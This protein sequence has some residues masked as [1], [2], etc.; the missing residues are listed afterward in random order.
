[1]A[2]HG[3]SP[4]SDR[5]RPLID[6]G[7]ALAFFLLLPPDLRGYQAVADEFAVSVRTVERHGREGNWWQ[8]ARD[9]DE[10]AQ[11]EAEGKLVQARVEQMGEYDQLIEGAIVHVAREIAAGRARPNVSD[12]IRLIKAR[13]ELWQQLDHP[14]PTPTE[15]AATAPASRTAAHKLEVVRAL[16]ESGALTGLLAA[17]DDTNGYE[18][19]DHDDIHQPEGGSQ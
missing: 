1:M 9:V 8:R 12:L 14:P 2:R 5:G 7:K 18:R 13:L 16:H 11:R 4:N 10:K 19:A 6:W 17:L 3:R 15:P